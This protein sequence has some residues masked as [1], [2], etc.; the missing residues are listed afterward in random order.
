MGFVTVSSRKFLDGDENSATA[1][2][3]CTSF[4][5]RTPFSR[6]F[7]E[8][9]RLP[10]GVSG[11]VLRPPCN[12]QRPLANRSRR[13]QGVPARVRALHVISRNSSGSGGGSG[14]GSQR[15]MAWPSCRCSH[16]RHKRALQQHARASVG[17]APASPRGCLLLTFVATLPSPSGQPSE[18]RRSERQCPQPICRVAQV[19][20]LG[21]RARAGGLESFRGGLHGCPV[22]PD[23]C[24][25]CVRFARFAR[26][27]P[28]RFPLGTGRMVKPD[29]QTRYPW[30]T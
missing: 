8:D 15:A 26:V 17:D 27:R 25:V 30:A 19:R 11:P 24:P 1:L 16:A 13:L 9:L 3:A 10:S 6:L 28:V 2:P 7:I 18:G 4:A 5:G 22:C 21:A 12:L 14:S 29:G 20:R 23:C